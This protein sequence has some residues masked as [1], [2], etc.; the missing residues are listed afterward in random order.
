[1]LTCSTSTMLLRGSRLNALMSR[2]L[3]TLLSSSATSRRPCG[4]TCLPP[5]TMLIRPAMTIGM[6][7]HVRTESGSRRNP[8]RS[9]RA[10]THTSRM[11]FAKLLP[12]ELDEQALK[13][14]LRERS[15]ADFRARGGERGEHRR[16]TA[17]CIGE[18]EQ[19]Q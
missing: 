16:Q 2:L 6:A 8:R 3:A 19:E 12:G 7:I 5:K 15:A 9:L 4:C 18:R 13:A 14:R 1:V 11:L 10:L 17:R